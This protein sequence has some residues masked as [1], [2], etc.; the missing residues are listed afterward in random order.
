MENKLSKKVV[1]RAA[2]LWNAGEPLTEI[3][4]ALGVT[5]EQVVAALESAGV[6]LPEEAVP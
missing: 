1:R 5:E 6:T 2:Y 4:E 3:A